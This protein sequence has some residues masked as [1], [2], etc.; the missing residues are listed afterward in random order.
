MSEGQKWVICLILFR[1]FCHFL[2]VPEV[3][4]EPKGATP[5]SSLFGVAVF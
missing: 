2:E 3:M 1:N 5:K 4:P